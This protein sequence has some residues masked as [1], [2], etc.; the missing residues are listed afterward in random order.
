MSLSINDLAY[1]KKIHSSTEAY[2]SLI[3]IK[4]FEKGKGNVWTSE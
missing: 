4:I 2:L 3:I 1:R